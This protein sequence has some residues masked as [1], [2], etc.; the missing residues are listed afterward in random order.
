M[1]IAE[2][3]KRNFDEL[4]RAF[5]NDHVALLEVTDK[6]TNKPAVVVVAVGFDGSTYDLVPMARMFD[7]NPYEELE[8]PDSDEP[9]THSQS[10]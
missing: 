6:V 7:G 8:A 10:S 4:T 9:T 2:G 1:A 5:A 3:Y